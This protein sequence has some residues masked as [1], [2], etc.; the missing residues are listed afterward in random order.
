VYCCVICS[1]DPAQQARSQWARQAQGEGVVV[2]DVHQVKDHRDSVGHKQAVDRRAGANAL[3][4]GFEA[5]GAAEQARVESTR[6]VIVAAAYW[7]ALQKIAGSHLPHL[8]LLMRLVKAEG[9]SPGDSF[10]YSHHRYFISSMYALS[11]MLLEQQL[12]LLRKSPYFTIMLDES[13][14]LANLTQVGFVTESGLW[15]DAFC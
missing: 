14:D 13:T 11:D 7:L 3:A 5:M 6:H 12:Q 9:F 2:R 4:A 1:T 10:Q 8:L 15:Q